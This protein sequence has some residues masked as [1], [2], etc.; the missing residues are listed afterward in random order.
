MMT[1]GLFNFPPP[2]KPSHVSTP[3]N[4]LDLGLP[5]VVQEGLLKTWTA[6]NRKPKRLEVK[7]DKLFFRLKMV[8]FF[9]GSS[10]WGFDCSKGVF[11]EQKCLFLQRIQKNS[12]ILVQQD[13]HPS[14]MVFL[15]KT[16]WSSKDG[17]STHLKKTKCIQRSSK[18]WLSIFQTVRG[19][20]EYSFKPKEFK[21]W[22]F[23]P[24]SLVVT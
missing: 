7:E 13:V 20:K 16:I 8:G 11:G 18:K 24:R 5:S 6:G 19:P 3:Q 2:K 23:N 17:W 10:S 1:G 12:Q 15:A 21:P 9:W 22:P 4:A 14:I